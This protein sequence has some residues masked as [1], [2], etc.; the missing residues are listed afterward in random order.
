[1]ERDQVGGWTGW[2][3]VRSR[4]VVSVWLLTGLP[5]L[6]N[7]ISQLQIW[8]HVTKSR[9]NTAAVTIVDAAHETPGPH[10]ATEQGDSISPG[11]IITVA[12][13]R[14]KNHGLWHDHVVSDF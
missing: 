4:R 1:M 10:P 14:L 8:D 3:G 13:R 11:F 7:S 2:V 9:N 12:N 6:P 5:S